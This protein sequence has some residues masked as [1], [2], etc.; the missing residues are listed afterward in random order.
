MLLK[1]IYHSQDYLKQKMLLHEHGWPSSFPLAPI[2]FLSLIKKQSDLYK[3]SQHRWEISL[4]HKWMELAQHWHEVKY[5][6]FEHPV[7]KTE[8]MER[9][10]A[11]NGQIKQALNYHIKKIED[12]EYALAADVPLN[13]SY[14]GP[15]ILRPSSHIGEDWRVDITPPMLMERFNEVLSVNQDAP[16]APEMKK[17]LEAA[18]ERW[19][20]TEKGIYPRDYVDEEDDDE[21]SDYEPSEE[22]EEEEDVE[23]WEIDE[24]DEELEF[25]IVMLEEDIKTDVEGLRERL[26]GYEIGQV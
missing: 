5:P 26:A 8:E 1:L 19:Q 22:D 6:N 14:R 25:D 9:L 3:E 13:T 2:E 24:E 11:L 20:L 17:I 4:D 10:Q 16:Q 7:T 23:E 18:Y 21:T 12:R 15:L